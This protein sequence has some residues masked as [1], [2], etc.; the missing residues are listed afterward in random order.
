MTD[1]MIRCPITGKE[2]S[3]G[4]DTGQF[5]D[6][7]DVPCRTLCPRCGRVH[8]WWPHDA[9]TKDAGEENTIDTTRSLGGSKS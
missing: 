1:L 4:L 5:P 9:W 3:T 7:P 6:V 8:R 2:Y